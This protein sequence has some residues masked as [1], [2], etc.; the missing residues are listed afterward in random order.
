MASAASETLDCRGRAAPFPPIETVGTKCY[1]RFAVDGEACCTRSAGQG[2]SRSKPLTCVVW[3]EHRVDL[4]GGLR[5]MLPSEELRA[6]EWISD[7]G[8]DTIRP[9]RR[10][11]RVHA[12][13]TETTLH[14]D[15]G[16]KDQSREQSKMQSNELLATAESSSAQDLLSPSRSSLDGLRACILVGGQ[17]ALATV[18]WSTCSVLMTVVNHI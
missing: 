16:V 15:V 13:E 7:D 1:L 2:G 14:E 8:D 3:Y 6:E 10:A 18:F 4:E 9:R 5:L 11:L 17:T 12:M